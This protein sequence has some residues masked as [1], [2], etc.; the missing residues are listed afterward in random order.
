MYINIYITLRKTIYK[1]KLFKYLKH[2]ENIYIQ[3]KW[4]TSLIT[5]L[6]CAIYILLCRNLTALLEN[7]YRGREI[8]VCDRE[9]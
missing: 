7:S 1:I 5:F 2:T 4:Y 9:G 3:R 8:S 6:L